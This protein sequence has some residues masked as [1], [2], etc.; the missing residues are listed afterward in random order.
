MMVEFSGVPAVLGSCA[1]GGDHTRTRDV[2]RCGTNVCRR[3]SAWSG[4]GL[5]AGVGGL[6]MLL[7]GRPDLCARHGECGRL[8]SAQ[9]RRSRLSD[10]ASVKTWTEAKIVD[11]IGVEIVGIGYGHF[12]E[13][14]LSRCRTRRRMQ[15]SRL[16]P[17]TIDAAADVARQF[18]I[19]GTVSVSLNTAANVIA[20]HW[21]ATA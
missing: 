4:I 21:A 16:Q 3:P 19:I 2:P 6:C 17:A 15:F 20:T 11:P 8:H 1:P 10:L 12:G 13:A 14:L 18:V 9:A 5:G 7:P